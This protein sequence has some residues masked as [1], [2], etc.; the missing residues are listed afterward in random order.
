MGTMA[1][2]W[3]IVNP[4]ISSEKRWFKLQNPPISAGGRDDLPFVEWLAK[5]KRKMEIDNDIIDMPRRAMAY[6]MNRVGG[7]AF[8]HLEPRAWENRPAK[9]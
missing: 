9:P 2:P 4:A 3:V 8:G 7:M 1:Q 6:V 5:M